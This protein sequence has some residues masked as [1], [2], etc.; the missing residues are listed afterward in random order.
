MS[1]TSYIKNG[2]LPLADLGLNV[3]KRSLT[4]KEMVYFHLS[5]LSY[6]LY[7][8]LSTPVSISSEVQDLSLILILMIMSPT[9][10]VVAD[11]TKCCPYTL[12]TPKLIFFFKIKS[13]QLM[14]K[15]SYEFVS[16]SYSNV[17]LFGALLDTLKND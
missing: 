2:L 4:T 11:L 15:I 14:R 1:S 9:L 10:S 3:D 13:F 5:S 8:C 6:Y 16:Q 17:N 7:V 12:H